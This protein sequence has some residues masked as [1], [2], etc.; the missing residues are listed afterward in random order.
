[1]SVR[2]NA[3]S[4]MSCLVLLVLYLLIKERVL[5]AAIFYGLS[6]HLKIYP[7]MYSVTIMMYLTRPALQHS[8]SFEHVHTICKC[9]VKSYLPL[10]RWGI[11]F[12]SNQ[13]VLDLHNTGQRIC[14]NLFV[15]PKGAQVGKM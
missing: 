5:L 3:E 10:A 9:A 1:V 12:K 13:T 7:V 4:V 8:E 11:I 6:V 14:A 2:G 15:F